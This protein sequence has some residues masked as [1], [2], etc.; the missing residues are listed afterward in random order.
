MLKKYI[1]IY[2]IERKCAIGPQ[3]QS[4]PY[5]ALQQKY[6][7]ITYRYWP[8]LNYDAIHHELLQ[9][10]ANFGYPGPEILLRIFLSNTPNACSSEDAI[11]QVSAPYNKSGNMSDL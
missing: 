3:R 1:H 4:K 10:G 11:V 7:N 6:T 2:R 8:Q 9:L 5:I